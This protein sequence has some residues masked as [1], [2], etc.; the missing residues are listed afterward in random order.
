MEV[1]GTPIIGRPTGY[2]Q[3]LADKICELIADGNSL[4][5]ICT[6]DDMPSK[7]SVF[8]WLI[9]HKD[10][11]DQYARAREAQADSLFD[12]ILDIADESILDTYTD[13]DGNVKTDS[14]VI[15]RSKLRVDA[16]KWMAGKLRPKVYG[17]KST[18]EITGPDGGP[19]KQEIALRPQLTKDEWMAAHGVGT[20]SRPA[21]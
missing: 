4:R 10:F 11:S 21:K 19:V 17:E 8:K 1:S 3:G 2:S 18:Q 15:G 12:D 14:E 7:S 9:E 6:E 20:A 5:K 13:K 16:R